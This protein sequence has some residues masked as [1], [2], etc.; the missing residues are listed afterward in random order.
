MPEHTIELIAVG[1]GDLFIL[2][3]TTMK[4]DHKKKPFRCKYIFGERYALRVPKPAT[5][6]PVMIRPNL[7]AMPKGMTM[8]TMDQIIRAR[9]QNCRMNVKEHAPLSAR[10]CVDHGVD[11]ETTEGHVNRAADRGC[12]V[13]ACS[14]SY[15]WCLG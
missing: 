8:E 11:V 10:A 2:F 14:A 15:F 1:C 6:P 5:P 13:S 4:V 12:C 7:E 9:G 3:R